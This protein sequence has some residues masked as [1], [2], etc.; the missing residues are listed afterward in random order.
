MID[1]KRF[2]ADESG[3]VSYF[4]MLLMVAAALLS[5]LGMEVMRIERQRLALQAEVDDC[6]LVAATQRQSLTPQVAFTD[7]MDN[8]GLADP[9]SQFTLDPLTG[10]ISATSGK[11]VDTVFMDSLGIDQ[12]DLKATSG[13]TEPILRVEIA[14]VLESSAAMAG[15]RMTAMK[16]A[17]QHFAKTLLES[18]E[19]GN[20]QITLVPYGGQVNLGDTL[21]RRFSVTDLPA[22]DSG[23][24]PELVRCLDLPD[25]AYRSATPAL[26]GLSL[27]ATANADAT[28][29]TLSNGSYVTPTDTAPTTGATPVAE[30]MLCP[31]TTTNQVRLPNFGADLSAVATAAGRVAFLQGLIGDLQPLG[32]SARHMAL[33]WALALYDPSMVKSYKSFVKSGLMHSIANGVPLDFGNPAA[34]KIVVLLGHGPATTD[35]QVLSSAN[36]NFRSGTASSMS[37]IWRAA[38]GNYSILHPVRPADVDYYVPHLH[39]WLP[40]PWTSGGTAATQL[41]WRQVWAALRMSYVAYQFYGRPGVISPQG[42]LAPIRTTVPPSDTTRQF[43]EACA[44]ARAN[45]VVVY[46]IAYE[47]AAQDAAALANCATTPSR[48]YVATRDTLDAAMATVAGNIAKL[49]VRQ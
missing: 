25:S 6:V 10:R 33:R 30:A 21:A 32:G 11:T 20:V 18:D 48:H 47:A 31:A 1:P 44:M 7:C 38:D 26:I 15:A 27:P 3:T 2:G 13:A 39:Q 22:A 40:D 14:L 36:G 29:P 43:A 28:S 24:L 34:L 12:V 23:A 4:G 49:R 17:A 16:A 9:A 5:G 46:T 37:P 41:T 42:A 8:A 45:K 35:I 19:T